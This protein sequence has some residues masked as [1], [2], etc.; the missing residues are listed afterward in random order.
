MRSL[1]AI[2]L[3]SML[4]L[5]A[6]AS[7]QNTSHVRL[8]SNVGEDTGPSW[9]PRGNTIAYMRSKGVS[10]VPFDIWQ[11]QADA[12]GQESVLA[13]GPSGGFGLASSL[14]WVGNTGRLALEERVVLF[15]Y[16]FFDTTFAPFTRTV[17][18]GSDA[19]FTRA[20]L[21]D[22]GGGG[23]IV[24]ISRDGL[25]AL[26]RFSTIGGNGDVSLRVGPVSSMTGQSVT[27]FGTAR[28]QQSGPPTGV[29][30]AT[31][32]GALSPDGS[33]FVVALPGGTDLTRNDLFLFTTS[34]NTP[35]KNLTRSAANG[36]NSIQPTFSPDGSKIV[37]TSINA[38]AGE[39]SFDLF[40]INPNGTGLTRITS[41]PNFTEAVPSY[42][43]D[44]TRLAIV[45]LHTDPTA[46]P[47]L[48]AGE[49][50]NANIYALTI[51]DQRIVTPDTII[52]QPPTVTVDGRKVRV[53]FEKFSGA[54]PLRFTP[55]G[56]SARSA[57]KK[58]PK[59]KSK[60]GFD[61]QLT[62]TNTGNGSTRRIVSKRDVVTLNNLAPGSYTATYVARVVRV[63]GKKT[64]VVGS[65][66]PSP[67]ASF[68]VS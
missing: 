49:S 68:Q 15:E 39:T 55:G 44:G 53:Q 8:T 31:R 12:P 38:G 23:G 56:A 14:S 5:A 66:Q 57:A 67:A 33:Q 32:G 51:S 65:T 7:A 43:P 37:F 35:G 20:L 11:V 19:A 36:F 17:S 58:K 24:A 21:I 13:T 64:K 29:Q 40:S 27:Q 16:M 42:S 28:F 18:D 54:S 25:T 1:F 4:L 2:P 45:G 52:T 41:T 63:T 62:V 3:V 48:A 50:I 9:D 47:P 60:I 34:G 22:G 61:Y 59:K 6:G 30:V 46:F 10:S 26:T